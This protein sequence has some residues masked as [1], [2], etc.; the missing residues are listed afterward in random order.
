MDLR[1]SDVERA[2]ALAFDIKPQ[3]MG[4]FR[5]RIRHLR[6]AN[7]AGLP[8]IGTGRQIVYTIEHARFF[9]L[10]LRLNQLGVMPEIIG[11]LFSKNR[12][13]IAV[14]FEKARAHLDATFFAALSIRTFGGPVGEAG[15]VTLL[16]AAG[17]SGIDD[18]GSFERLLE[19]STLPEH[20]RPYI[21][22]NITAAEKLLQESLVKATRTRAKRDTGHT[23]AE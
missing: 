14:W 19:R 5:G 23:A 13:R 3:E 7:V 15:P 16:A 4:M 11:K 17:F 2:L 21:V 12:D 22:V 1:Y 8:Q 18:E 20:S 10:A 9:L 6:K